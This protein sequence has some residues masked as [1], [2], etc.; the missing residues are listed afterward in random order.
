MTASRN[1]ATA[2]KKIKTASKASKVRKVA[3]TAKKVAK[4]TKKAVRATEKAMK[5]IN[6]EITENQGTARFT[7]NASFSLHNFNTY[8]IQQ[9]ESRKSLGLHLE[10]QKTLLVET[11]GPKACT[12]RTKMAHTRGVPTLDAVKDPVLR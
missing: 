7:Y 5:Q 3:K 2:A 1:A 10:I 12:R 8:K 4:T 9:K 6:D 11:T